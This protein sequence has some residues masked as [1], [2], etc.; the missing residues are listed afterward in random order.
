VQRL[1]VARSQRQAQIGLALSGFVVFVQFVLFLSIGTLLWR[2]YAGREFGRGDDVLPTFIAESL[3][4]PSKGF[5]LA[6]VVAAALSP[7]LNSV[8]STTLRDFYV[9][10]VEPTASERRQIR[11]GRIF[12]VSWGVAQTVVAIFAQRASSALEA[13][14]A[15]LSYASGPTVGAF[16][17]AVFRRRT[18]P[19]PVLLGMAVG[20]L[21]PF[22]ANRVTPVAWTWNV[23]LGATAS[24]ASAVAADHVLRWIAPIPRR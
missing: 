15:A 10:F 24:Y 19:V 16:L 11:L 6:A 8:A 21:A 18:G 23:A 13:G 4:G 3:A 5:L 20:F 2:F 14:L 9:P 1:L 22:V 17:L 12:T 7:S